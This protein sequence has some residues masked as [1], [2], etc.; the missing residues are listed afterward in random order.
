MYFCELIEKKMIIKHKFPDVWQVGSKYPFC[1]WQLI[2]NKYVFFNNQLFYLTN[3]LLSGEIRMKNQKKTCKEQGSA[4][5]TICPRDCVDKR[6]PR[7]VPG[8]LS[9]PHLHH[10]QHCFQNSNSKQSGD[11]LTKQL[12]FV[13]GVLCVKHSLPLMLVALADHSNITFFTKPSVSS[14]FPKYS[15]I[16]VHA[17]HSIYSTTVKPVDS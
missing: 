14:L 16:P 9:K 6:S 8:S 1:T 10:S 17:F 15:Y 11:R 3:R 2:H 13:C 7:T 5:L 4:P 12:D